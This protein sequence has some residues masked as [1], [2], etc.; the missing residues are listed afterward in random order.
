MTHS[1]ASNN[2]DVKKEATYK[3][4]ISRCNIHSK[5]HNNKQLFLIEIV[6]RFQKKLEVGGGPGCDIFSMRSM[7]VRGTCGHM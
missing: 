3:L 5:R 6:F 4:N 1:M 7:G 2:E